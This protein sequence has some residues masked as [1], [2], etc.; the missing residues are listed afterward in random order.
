MT[1][2][3]R[4]LPAT[5]PYGTL[6]WC[7]TCGGE[8]SATQ[9]DYFLRVPDSILTCCEQPLE[10]VFKQTVFTP[11]NVPRVIALRTPGRKK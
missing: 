7:Q 11:V 4:D 5:A 6:L 8:Y 9:G 2:R 1:V 10:L 3:V